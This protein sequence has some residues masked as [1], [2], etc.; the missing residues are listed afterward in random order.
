MTT[1]TDRHEQVLDDPCPSCLGSTRI[2]FHCLQ[3]E[4]RCGCVTQ[5]PEGQ[6]VDWVNGYDPIICPKCGE[7]GRET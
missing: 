5:I 4:G 1:E 6:L 2:C 3:P 7:V